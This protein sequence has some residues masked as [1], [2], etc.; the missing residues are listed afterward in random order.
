MMITQHC[1][2]ALGPLPSELGLG[3]KSLFYLGL[4]VYFSHG[5]NLAAGEGSKQKADVC[6][7]KAAKYREMFA[8]KKCM[9]FLSKIKVNMVCG[10]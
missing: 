6:R 9:K 1:R 3:P 5:K 7:V 2:G 4:Q 10:S 8:L